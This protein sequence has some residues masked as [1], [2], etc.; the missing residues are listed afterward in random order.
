MPSWS[1]TFS[2]FEKHIQH[3]H[4]P[5]NTKMVKMCFDIYVIVTFVGWDA[6]YR[7]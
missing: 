7:C 5:I 1:F 3:L 6:F 2:I 4:L